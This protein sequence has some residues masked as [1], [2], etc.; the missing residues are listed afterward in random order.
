VCLPGYTRSAR[1]WQRPV[2]RASAYQ[3]RMPINLYDIA[4]QSCYRRCVV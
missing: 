3:L 1:R 4:Q 2:V